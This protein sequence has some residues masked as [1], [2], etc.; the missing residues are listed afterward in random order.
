MSVLSALRINKIMWLL[1]LL[2][3]IYLIHI[4]FS[5]SFMDC[6]GCVV[7]LNFAHELLISGSS[8]WVKVLL[9]FFHIIEQGGN[10]NIIDI[11]VCWVSMSLKIWRAH[12]ISWS[13]GLIRLKLFVILNIFYLLPE[14]R[15][16]CLI[17]NS[18]IQRIFSTL[19][20]VTYFNNW[21]C[22]LSIKIGSICLS[23]LLFSFFTKVL[24]IFR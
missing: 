21:S 16:L 13:L 14:G 2:L 18:I 12:Y 19:R 22:K 8:G 10:T 9:L 17:P 24:G 7:M 11:V 15:V 1:L 23:D 3:S 20:N 4:P 6:F 5:L